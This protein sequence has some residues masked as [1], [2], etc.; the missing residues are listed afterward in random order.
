MA[1]RETAREILALFLGRF[2][3]LLSVG[4]LEHFGY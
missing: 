1:L 3:T 4:R 2:F